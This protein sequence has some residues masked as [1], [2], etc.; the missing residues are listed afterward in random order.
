LNGL[1]RAIGV[2]KGAFSAPSTPSG[3]SGRWRLPMARALQAK[4]PVNA[5]V[6]PRNVRASSR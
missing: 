1:Q 2:E 5:A 6:S 3:K 4:L